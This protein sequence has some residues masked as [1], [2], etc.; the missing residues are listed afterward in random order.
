V[1][2][3]EVWCEALDGR[4]KDMKY[5]NAIE[6]N[7][8]LEATQG[9]TRSKNVIRRGYSSLQK[10]FLRSKQDVTLLLS[11]YNRV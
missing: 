4:Q 6:I 7:N 9:W 3:L 10:G 11:F 8:T 2:A 5:T 1:C